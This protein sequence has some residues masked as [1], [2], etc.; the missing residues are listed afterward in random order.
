MQSLAYVEGMWDKINALLSRR[1]SEV[2][3]FGDNLESFE[4]TRSDTLAAYL[5]SMVDEMVNTALKLPQEIER[6]AEVEAFE[7]NS[8]ITGNRRAHAELMARMEKEDIMEQ[9][10]AR[11]KV[12]MGENQSCTATTTNAV[13]SV[14]RFPR[15]SLHSPQWEHRMSDWRQ[16]RH[17]RGI[18]EFHRDITADNFMNP[19]DRVALFESFKATQKARHDERCMILKEL[20]D[21]RDATL[22]SERV[23]DV[24]QEF[25]KMNKVEVEAIKSLY[26]QLTALKHAKHDEAE[27]RREDL[28]H[29]LHNYGALHLEPDVG[30]FASEIDD[31]VNS[32]ELEEFFR[33]SGGLKPELV[34]ISK[35]L[36]DPNLIY[37]KLL[38]AAV[39]SLTVVQCGKDLEIVLEK[40]GKSSLRKTAQDTLERLRKATKSEVLT[41]LPVLKQQC[42]ALAL[43]NG[44]DALLKKELAL[45]ADGLQELVTTAEHSKQDNE[46]LNSTSKSRTNTAATGDDLNKTAATSAEPAAHAASS[47]APSEAAKSN[48]SNRS[49]RRRSVSVAGGGGAKAWEDN[50]EID[51]LQVRA[52]Q[53]KVGL[54]L[55]CC[56]LSDEFKEVLAQA[57]LGMADKRICN[58]RIDEAVRNE[59]SG[60]IEQRDYEQVSMGGDILNA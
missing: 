40:Q 15:R 39:E 50:V 6:V 19:P 51:M 43:V 2:V 29:E 45:A 23:N 59:C 18:R 34:K 4:R 13:L 42:T 54:L 16:L 47:R 12:R 1:T 58:G 31:V 21:M 28:R 44:I 22:A 38:D 35:Q 24:R 60:P 20:G 7:L 56:D 37:L 30:Y 55:A 53:K 14:T 25:S 26:D 17:D 46:K 52:I 49:S 27:K 36:R 48:R 32:A 9:V 3:Q 11:E 57:L 41:I 33:K 10:T 8:V 5:R